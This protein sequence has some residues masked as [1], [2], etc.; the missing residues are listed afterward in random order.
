MAFFLVFPLIYGGLSLAFGQDINWDLRNYHWYNAYAFLN[1]RSDRDL[2]VAQI[3]SFYNPILDVPFYLAA[4]HLPARV[5]GFLLGAIQGLNGLLLYGLAYAMLKPQ[6]PMPRTLLSIAAAIVGMS[7]GGVLGE[8]GTDFWDNIVSLGLLSGLLLINRNIA[9]CGRQMIGTGLA[10]I[11]IGAAAA[12]KQPHLLYVAGIGLAI[13]TLPGSVR[14]RT[15]RAGSYGAGAF[16]GILLTSGFWMLHLAHAY[17]S[18]L[19]PYFNNILQSP[20]AD[21]HF[22]FRDSQFLPKSLWHA[23]FFPVYFTLDP[24]LVG[25]IRQRGPAILALYIILPLALLQYFVR[26]RLRVE[27]PPEARTDTFVEPVFSRFLVAAIVFSYLVWLVMFG[28]YRYAIPLEM[29]APLGLIAAFA[30]CPGPVHLRT[31]LILVVFALSIFG[32]KRGIWDRG[33]W[34]DRYVEMSI[35]PKPAGTMVLMAGGSDP[36]GFL[37]SGFP[38][39]F[40]IVRIESNFMMPPYTPPTRFF[41]LAQSKI[42]QHQGPFS[43]VFSTPQKRANI[44]QA[45]SNYGLLLDV[46]TCRLIPNSLTET[47]IVICDVSRQ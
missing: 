39:D 3:Q 36:M 22:D 30:L 1:H 17:G 37:A 42:A 19:F 45:L 29:L 44:D 25:E 46:E 32:T 21:I 16:A 8:L 33:P 23:V 27:D 12:A 9:N 11:L 35:P 26:R 14:N 15:M 2:L 6:P 18:P 34:H 40:P 38:A 5:L 43:I 24:G 47:R 20:L 31:A 41:D 7:G 13:L 4:T 28:I 10:G